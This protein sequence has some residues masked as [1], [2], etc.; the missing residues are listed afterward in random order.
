MGVGQDEAISPDNGASPLTHFT[1]TRFKSS[2]QYNCLGCFAI[3]FSRVKIF[4]GNRSRHQ[5][6]NE[7]LYY[8]DQHLQ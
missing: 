8:L 5:Q 1:L 6:N 3:N 4:S 2:Y 7:G